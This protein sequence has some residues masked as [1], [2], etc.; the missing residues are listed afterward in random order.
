MTLPRIALAESASASFV[1]RYA[2][3][4][5][6]VRHMGKVTSSMTGG[7]C[8]P[9]SNEQQYTDEDR[10]RIFAAAREALEAAE[11]TLDAP[12]PEVAELPV[13]DNLAKWKRE[14]REQEERFARERAEPQPLTEWE[15]AQLQRDQLAGT[16]EEQKRFIFDVLAEVAAELRAD[17][18]AEFEAKIAEVNV[19]LGLLRADVTISKTFA[20]KEPSG[21]VLDL[22]TLPLRKRA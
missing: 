16:V 6:P 11:R 4:A 20:A 18:R 3:S 19:E 10:A 2:A 15:A 5:N 1:S 8:W 12:R 7:V 22:P 9:V 13:E 21:E 14:A 17:L